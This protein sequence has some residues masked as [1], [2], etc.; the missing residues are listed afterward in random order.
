MPPTA[1]AIIP[2]CAATATLIL[3]LDGSARRADPERDDWPVITVSRPNVRCVNLDTVTPEEVCDPIMILL[4]PAN[5]D[6]AMRPSQENGGYPAVNLPVDPGMAASDDMW[7]RLIRYAT[8]WLVPLVRQPRL[9]WTS[10]PGTMPPV[11]VWVFAHVGKSERGPVID[12]IRDYKAVYLM[13]VGGAAWLWSPAPSSKVL[14]FPE[15]G[16]GGDLRV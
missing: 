14:A 15:L 1:V 8:K 9:V 10:L 7:A 11:P 6:R 4:S 16:N 12:A 5:A 2:N 3:Q 13:A